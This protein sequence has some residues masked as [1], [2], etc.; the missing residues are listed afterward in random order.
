MVATFTYDAPS[1]IV[2]VVGTTSTFFDDCVAADIANFGTWGFHTIAKLGTAQYQN[3][4]SG[5]DESFG[6]CVC[7]CVW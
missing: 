4:L 7:G 2:T 6:A 5:F 3:A 1:N